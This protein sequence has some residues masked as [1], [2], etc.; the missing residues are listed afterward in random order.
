[1]LRLTAAAA[2]MG[3]LLLVGGGA[4]AQAPKAGEA[5][6]ETKLSVPP[7]EQLAILIQTA[8][9]A[10]SQANLTGN[11]SVLHALAAPGFQKAN[12]PEKLA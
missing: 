4:S 2:A 12:P 1:M 3:L 6:A 10:A 11:Y 5:K 9:V 7:P 8:V